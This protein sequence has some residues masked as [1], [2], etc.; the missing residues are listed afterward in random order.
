M[1]VPHAVQP[2]EQS[3]H[4][5]RAR[6]DPTSEGSRGN[7]ATQSFPGQAFAYIKLLNK[8]GDSSLQLRLVCIIPSTCTSMKLPRMRERKPIFSRLSAGRKQGRITSAHP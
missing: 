7:L 6:G 8:I 3:L 2:E 4:I 1:P 5:Q